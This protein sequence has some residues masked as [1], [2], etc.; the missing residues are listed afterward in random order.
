M[1]L[2]TD[3]DF[4]FTESLFENNQSQ[5][6]KSHKSRLE[7]QRFVFRLCLLLDFPFDN[8]NPPA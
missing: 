2:L 8:P 4:A 5:S 6:I 1:I 3:F 7:M